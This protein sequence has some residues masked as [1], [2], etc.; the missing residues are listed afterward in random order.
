MKTQKNEIFVYHN[1]SSSRAK[2]VLALAR[3][4][5]SNV[6]DVEYHKTP[7]T[8]TLWEQL[9]SKLDLRPKDLLNRADPYYQDKIAGRDFTRQSWLRILIN[10]PDLIKAPIVVC[11]D[12]AILCNNPSDILQLQSKK[13]KKEIVI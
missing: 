7:L 9:L 1:R 4:I 13:P 8:T 12:K 6:R 5:S 3:T 10:N 11:G 2:K